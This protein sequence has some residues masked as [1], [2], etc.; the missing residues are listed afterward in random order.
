MTAE[1][2]TDPDLVAAARTV[3]DGIDT[4]P[5]SCEFA[6]QWIKADTVYTKE[7]DGLVQPWNGNVFVNPPG[8]CGGVDCG[9]KKGCGCR[10][11]LR[12]WDK[13][14]AEWRIGMAE[15]IFWVGF[16]IEQLA[17][18]QQHRIHP[19]DFP[20]CIPRKRLDFLDAF[21]DRQGSP[22]HSNYICLLPSSKVQVDEFQIEM[23]DWGHTTIPNQVRYKDDW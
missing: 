15:S 6:N 13:A 18:F 23:L 7:D 11:P 5:A 17:Q 16:S 14:V 1:H 8:T 21:G 10:L 22:T 2:Y 20:L 3:L 12:F 4:D 9:R 19:M